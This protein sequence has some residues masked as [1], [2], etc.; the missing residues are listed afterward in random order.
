MKI[1][2]DMNLPPRIA[3][4][5]NDKGMDAVHWYGI[6]A[7]SASDSELLSYAHQHGYIVL[8]CDLDFTALLAASQSKTVAVTIAPRIYYTKGLTP[9][10]KNKKTNHHRNPREPHNRATH[11]KRAGA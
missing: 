3:E 10:A 9:I 2:V 6:G 4:L 1:L 5:L 7:P 8:T 11:R